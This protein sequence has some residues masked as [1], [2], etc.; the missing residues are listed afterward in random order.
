MAEDTVGNIN[1]P[2]ATFVYIND[3]SV[4]Y[5]IT[6]DRSVALAIGNDLSTNAAL[7]VLRATGKRPL[8]PRY[9]LLQLKSDPSVRKKA[10]CGDYTNS[11][12]LSSAATDVTINGVVWTI[13]GR[14][15]EK[16]STLVI[17]AVPP[18]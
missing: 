3:S 6:L 10:F 11:N 1:G 9:L 8:E 7:P 15:G 18:P 12:F 5:N 2:R 14:V 16:R 4:N 17:D 13:I